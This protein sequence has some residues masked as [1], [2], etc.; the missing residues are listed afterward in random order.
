[1]GAIGLKLKFFIF[2]FGGGVGTML[3]PNEVVYTFGGSYVYAAGSYHTNKLCSRRSLIKS[4][5]LD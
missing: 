2:F 4:P 3:T 5:S 1:L